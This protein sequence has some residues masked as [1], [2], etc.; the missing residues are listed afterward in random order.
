VASNY[1]PL[2][3]SCA[4]L[5]RLGISHAGVFLQRARLVLTLAEA[6]ILLIMQ[7][8]LLLLL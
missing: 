2:G 3:T 8:L 1:R 4:L 7:L 6:L 5:V